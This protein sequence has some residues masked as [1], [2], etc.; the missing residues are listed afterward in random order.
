VRIGQL[1]AVSG[2][3]GYHPDGSLADGLDAQLDVAFHNVRQAL[4]THGATLDDVLSVDVYLAREEHFAPMN[5]LYIR[6][7]AE[8][9]PA[10]TTITSGLRTDVLFEISVLAVLG[11]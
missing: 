2:Q 10:R 4:A 11:S 3:C 7:F 5:V 8:P 6:Y 9:R 1:V